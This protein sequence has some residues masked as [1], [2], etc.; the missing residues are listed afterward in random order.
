MHAHKETHSLL[1]EDETHSTVRVVAKDICENIFLLPPIIPFPPTPFA[2]PALCAAL[3]VLPGAEA[4]SGATAE[5]ESEAATAAPPALSLVIH[6]SSATRF[7]SSGTSC[8]AHTNETERY[9]K[10]GVGERGKERRRG[11]GCSNK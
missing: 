9:K 6:W 10:G 2:D 4:E 3:P 1:H 7:F 11:E 5:A 8:C